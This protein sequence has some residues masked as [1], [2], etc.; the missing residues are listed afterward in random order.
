MGE[1]VSR[2]N[3]I[4]KMGYGAFTMS[5]MMTI[6][7]ANAQG[8]WDDVDLKSTSGTMA[9]SDGPTAS[10]DVSSGGTVTVDLVI[11]YGSSWINL[12]LINTS[13]EALNGQ[14]NI[15]IYYSDGFS[16]TMSVPYL[17]GGATLSIN[18]RSDLSLPVT[19]TV[20]VTYEPESWTGHDAGRI[21]LEQTLE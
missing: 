7:N 2:R 17:G 21:V 3:A 13:S 19:V 15:D 6:L 18:D 12:D 10:A 5:T 11:D 1:G 4:K 8:V 9:I 16:D 20:T 14:I